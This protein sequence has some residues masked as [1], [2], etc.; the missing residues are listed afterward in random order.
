LP[1]EAGTS[2]VLRVRSGLIAVHPLPP[3]VVFHTCCDVTKSV[4][5]STGEKMTGIVRTAR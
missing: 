4:F 3:V 5:G 1:T 2:H